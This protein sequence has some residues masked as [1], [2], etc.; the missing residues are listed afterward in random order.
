MNPVEAMPAHFS[1]LSL[2]VNA[3]FVV[4]TVMAALVLASILS[5][6]IGFE[7]LLRY[8]AFSRQVRCLEASADSI[9]GGP[10]SSSSW[11]VTRLDEIASEPRTAGENSAEFKANIQ[12]ISS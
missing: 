9:P 6:T 5:W 11:L 3:D 12:A 2:A 8:T 7:K 4:Q 10:P 1:F